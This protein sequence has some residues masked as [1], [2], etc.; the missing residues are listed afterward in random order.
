M[1]DLSPC[2]AETRRVPM[3][4]ADGALRVLY[5]ID[6]MVLGGAEN[7]LAALIRGLDRSRVEPLL[8]T[9]R[10]TEVDLTNLGCTLFDARFTSFAA[11][12]I[13]R[14]VRDLRAFLREQRVH[15][16][17]AYFQDAVILAYLASVGWSHLLRVASFR[18]LGFWRTPGK[19][20]QL[21][22]VYPRYHGFL[23]NARCIA[24]Y[25]H[26]EF[27]IPEE[28]IQLIYNGVNPA[29]ASRE[30][31]T[32][33]D[34]L[35]VGLVA[36]LDR[37]VKRVDLFVR[38]A[39]LVSQA[40]PD[41]RF[42]VVGDGPLRPGLVQLASALGLDGRMAFLGQLVEPAREIARFDI[43]VLTSDSEG[44]S[45]AILEYMA[46]GVPT[47]ARRVGGNPEAV[48][49]GETG[50]LVNDASPAALAAAIL[51]LLREPA[52]RARLGR[53]AREV[54]GTSFTMDRQA[55]EHEAY[56]HRLWRDRRVGARSGR[57]APTR[58]RPVEA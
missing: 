37:A 8:C 55:R 45:N 18:D 2:T 36:T 23:A 3:E 38:A 7:Q 49:D 20:L 41:V 31:R 47:V 5:C 4:R 35:T 52:L 57:R 11:A 21:R 33:A 6:A 50:L 34:P 28:R 40:R 17:H 51:R 32:A 9:L 14:R 1:P 15:V 53:R 30:S 22:M 13:V 54:A 12:D 27:G 48:I 43:G 16:V 19:V 25:A 29:P 58:G 46:A 24:E 26:L 56:Y 44:L 39:S 42:V 10:G